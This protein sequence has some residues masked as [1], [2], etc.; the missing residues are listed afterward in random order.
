MKKLLKVSFVAMLVAAPFAAMATGEPMDAGTAP[1][2]GV[3]ATAVADV[4]STSYVKGAYNDV[5]GKINKVAET[6]AAGQTA[7]QV[8]TAITNAAGTTANTSLAGSNGVL[9][10]QVDGTHVT[11]DASGNL[12]L[13]ATDIAS[14]GKADTAL[15]SNSALNGANLTAGTVA[16][17]ALDSA[18]QTKLN[19]AAAA[20]VVTVH[21]T[22]NSDSTT[23]PANVIVNQ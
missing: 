19:N 3:D 21:T 11:R 20:K 17:T 6:A 8:T 22:W 1:F 5:V 18:T 4:A 15:Q 7:A 13:S 9:T 10:V 12:T 16:E 23:A 2:A 14:L